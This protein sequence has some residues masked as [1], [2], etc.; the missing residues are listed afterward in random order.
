MQNKLKYT[1][2]M[3]ID[4]RMTCPIPSNQ[5]GHCI[6]TSIITHRPNLHA[7]SQCLKNTPELVGQSN[8]KLIHRERASLYSQKVTSDG[9]SE[10]VL[11]NLHRTH[12]PKKVSLHAWKSSLGIS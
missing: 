10:T 4:S 3:E 7:P 2:E 8:R 9:Y 5:A 11:F 6:S 12:I 1:E